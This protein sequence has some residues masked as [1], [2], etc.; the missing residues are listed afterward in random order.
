MIGT[1]TYLDPTIQADPNL[2]FFYFDF[3]AFFASVEEIENPE[4]KNQPLIVGNRT[5]RSVV[6]TCNYLARSYGIK[7]GMPIAKALELCPQAIFATSHFRNYRKY[8]AKIFAMIAEQFNL[9]VHTLSIDEG[10]VC[11]RDL[12]PRK[13]FSLAKRIQRHVYEQLNF[14]ISIG[15]SNQFTLAKIFSNQAKPFGVKSCFSKEVKRKL[16]PLPIVELPGIGKRQ[17]DNAFKNNFHKIGDLAKCKDVT[18]FKRVFGIAWESL[19]AVALGETYT[20]SEQDVKSRSIAV[21]ETL[22]Y[23]NYSSNQLQQKLTSIFNELYARLQLSFQMC[24]GVVVQ[25]KSNDFIVNSHS[26]SIK[27]YTADYQTLLVIVKKL[28]NRLLMGVGLNIRLIGVSFFGLKNNPSSSRPEGLLFY[29]YQQA[30][31]KQ[32]TAHFAL[33]QMIY[34]INQSFGYEIIQRAKKLAAS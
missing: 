7:S 22:E 11:F 12:S 4:L 20:Q 27:K 10:F 17:L 21:S 15:I 23:L 19:H 33:D 34:E 13:A 3:D 5:S 6:S 29:E 14:H 30:K 8:S 26:Q 1:F 2:L 9:E 24:K 18:L 16:W 32:Q 31:P 28:F 25:L